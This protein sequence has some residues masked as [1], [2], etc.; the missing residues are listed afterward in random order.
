MDHGYTLIASP[1]EDMNIPQTIGK[2]TAWMCDVVIPEN[3]ISWA[4]GASNKHVKRASRTPR[5]AGK[6]SE[7]ARRRK[8][9]KAA[10]IARR[11]NRKR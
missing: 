8:A 3:L 5:K 2:S 11:N 10:R 4:T 1:D 6:R 7:L 9:A